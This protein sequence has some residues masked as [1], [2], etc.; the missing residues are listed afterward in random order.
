MATKDITDRQVCEAIRD[1]RNMEWRRDGENCW[2]YDLLTER[3]G[4]PF[5]VCWRAMERTYNRRLVE[6]GVN[7]RTGWLTDA[8]EILLKTMGKSPEGEKQ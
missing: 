6:C 4:Q 1:A 5:K 8:G 3:T 7:L 2:P